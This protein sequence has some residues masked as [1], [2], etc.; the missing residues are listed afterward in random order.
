MAA[1]LGSK[2]TTDEERIT[3]GYWREKHAQ[4]YEIQ[5]NVKA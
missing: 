3:R 2:A 1:L 5:A 4:E